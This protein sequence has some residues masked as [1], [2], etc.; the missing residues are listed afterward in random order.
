M[1]AA[2]WVRVRIVPVAV[3]ALVVLVVAGLGATATDL[4][5]WYQALEKPWWQPPDWLFGPAWTLIYALTAYAGIL[6]WGQ[7]QSLS[8]RTS[9]LFAF[10]LNVLLNILWTE[11][12]FGFRR[13]D[14]A[15]IE[16]GL[17]WLSIVVLMVVLARVSR[18][19]AWLL[20][21]YLIWVTLAAALNFEVV[22]LNPAF[23]G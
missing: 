10:G 7:S 16:V 23:G 19:A 21:P 12:F 3:A 22:R 11:L 6:A 18:T 4:G 9:I 17:L 8:A 2:K 20:L 1:K 13:P 14:W 15:L 5:P